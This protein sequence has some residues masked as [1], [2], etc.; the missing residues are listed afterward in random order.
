M[1][2]V[3]LKS[4]LNFGLMFEKPRYPFEYDHSIVCQSMSMMFRRV[5]AVHLLL[6]CLLELLGV[7]VDSTRSK[8]SMR[9]LVVNRMFHEEML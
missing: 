8:A 4:M 1:Q 7:D 9:V 3:R 6:D 2:D 5:Y